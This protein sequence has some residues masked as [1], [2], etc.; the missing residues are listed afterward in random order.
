MREQVKY[1]RRDT[2]HEETFLHGT[3]AREVSFARKVIFSKEKKT[4]NKQTKI[5][6]NKIRKNKLPTEGRVRGNSDSKKKLI[7]K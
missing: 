3:F 6:V 1:A 7:K 4:K 5:I 2:L